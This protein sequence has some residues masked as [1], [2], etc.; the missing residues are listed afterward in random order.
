MCALFLA[1]IDIFN[2][3]SLRIYHGYQLGWRIWTAKLSD[4]NIHRFW[5][6]MLMLSSSTYANSVD[7]LARFQRDCERTAKFCL[8]W[9][10]AV[11]EV[12]L[13]RI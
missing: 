9:Y 4:D 13:F 8:C 11:T 2:H 7:S 1:D 10:Q 3:T 5:V 6:W 12:V